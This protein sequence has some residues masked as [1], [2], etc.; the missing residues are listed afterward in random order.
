ML[1]C[2]EVQGLTIETSEIE[3]FATRNFGVHEMVTIDTN[4][5]FWS[6]RLY[7]EGMVRD[8]VKVMTRDSGQSQGPETLRLHRQGA[9]SLL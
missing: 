6:S 2:G 9:I 3:G 5:S 7:S 8:S 4:P 1:W